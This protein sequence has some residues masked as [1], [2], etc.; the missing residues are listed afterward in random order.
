MV[1]NLV[2]YDADDPLFYEYYYA[3]L[4][5]LIREMTAKDAPSMVLKGA[6]AVV[7]GKLP[8]GASIKA[9]YLDRYG[10]L[11]ASKKVSAKP[12]MNKIGD[13]EYLP[14]S[15][16]MMDAFLTDNTGRVISYAARPVSGTVKNRIAEVK[17]DSDITKDRVYTGTVKMD[18]S[19]A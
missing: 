2:P 3:F 12:G 9:D 4:G 6:C 17:L 11:L 13:P 10:A 14:A 18:G 19:P 1:E 8:A 5:A 7:S 16:A 15:A